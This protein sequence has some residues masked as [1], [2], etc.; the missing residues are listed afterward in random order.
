MRALPLL[1]LLVPACP[2]TPEPGKLQT[3]Q[4]TACVAHVVELRK[5]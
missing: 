3:G 1:L 2:A 4:I 5:L